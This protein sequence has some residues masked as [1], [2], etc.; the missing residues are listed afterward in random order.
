MMNNVT[1]PDMYPFAYLQH[2]IYILYKLHGY[3]I[4]TTL[5]FIRVYHQIP[6]VPG[7]VPKTAVITTFGL[8][9]FRVVMFGL[10][11]AA[12]YIDIAFK[13]L[14]FCSACIG[15]IL[16]ASA[17]S[18]EHHQHL[19][20]VSERLQQFNHHIKLAKCIFGASTVNYLGYQVD[21]H[22]SRPLPGKSDSNSGLRKA[23]E[24]IPGDGKFL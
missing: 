18:G 19:C 7:D 24:Q 23:A 4:F 8:F 21:E 13:R 14:E 22:G 6:V 9:E 2:F 11:N 17:T 3:K 1:I 16:I 10:K 12:R 15:D 5:D 20:I